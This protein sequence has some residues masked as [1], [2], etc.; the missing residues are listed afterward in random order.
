M[1]LAPFYST[2]HVHSIVRHLREPEDA[3]ARNG[4]MKSPAKYLNVFRLGISRNAGPR[5]KSRPGENSSVVGH[6]DAPSFFLSPLLFRST[7]GT[8]GEVLINS[9]HWRILRTS[10]SLFLN[11]SR[12]LI[13]PSYIPGI[14]HGRFSAAR[15]L[16]ST[17]SRSAF[18]SAV[19]SIN[20]FSCRDG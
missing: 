13:N 9:L 14:L 2:F 5:E 15:K 12:H 17:G 20:R 11:A 3:A 18:G 8:A 16:R 10:S 19:K 7:P 6:G 4:E 1:Y